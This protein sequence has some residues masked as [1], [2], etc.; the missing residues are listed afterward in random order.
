MS[1]LRTY[2]TDG[3]ICPYCGRQF[4]PDDPSYY[5]QHQMT[6]LEC[7]NCRGTFS[8]EV[9]HSVSWACSER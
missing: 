9:A 7:N 5:D 1:K 6:E 3:P 8:V 4:T 2:S